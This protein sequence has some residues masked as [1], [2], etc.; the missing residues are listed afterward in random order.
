MIPRNMR[1]PEA[2]SF[3]K[4]ILLYDYESP[5]WEGVLGTDATQQTR[6]GCLI[7]FIEGTHRDRGEDHSMYRDGRAGNPTCWRC[8]RDPTQFHWC[9]QTSAAGAFPL[10]DGLG[11]V[12]IVWVGGP[13][14]GT[15]RVPTSFAIV[16]FFAPDMWNVGC[17]CSA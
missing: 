6:L 17:C 8:C 12:F 11:P 16:K 1:V 13:T 5:G 10:A 4:P 9:F 3:G 15:T 2:P 14:A 7:L